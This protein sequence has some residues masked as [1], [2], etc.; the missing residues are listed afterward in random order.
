MLRFVRAG[1][2][3]VLQRFL[4]SRPQTVLDVSSPKVPSLLLAQLGSQVTATDLEDQA[5][6]D[7]WKKSADAVGIKNYTAQFQ[8]ARKL[9]HPDNSFDFLYSISV[10]EHIPDRGDME[11]L[12]E[13][14]RVVK[15]G[16]T[17]VVEVPYRRVRKDVFASYDSKGA[18]LPA[19]RFYER[20]YDRES[21]HERLEKADNL[22][23]QERWIL[24]EWLPIDPW[25]E[26]DRLPRIL[27][28]AALPLEPFLAAVNGWVRKD[29]AE[30]RPLAA[31]LIYRKRA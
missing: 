6:F 7:R 30:G 14:Q 24:G 26:A 21:L 2:A 10:I 31:L 22:E 11:A 25:I 19:P 13:F 3:F 15:P 4:A 17:I 8:D 27:R 23:L 1:N 29:D 20:Y 18:P 28:L 5:I 16:G 9:T 12:L